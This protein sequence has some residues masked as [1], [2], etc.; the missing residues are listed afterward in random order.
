[1]FIE[2]PVPELLSDSGKSRIPPYKQLFG[3]ETCDTA[4]IGRFLNI[5]CFYK[6]VNPK[7]FKT[8]KSNIGLIVLMP[9]ASHV[10]RKII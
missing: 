5:S 6:H 9:E 7:G 10:Y 3:I 1:M 2:K 4:G 8:Y